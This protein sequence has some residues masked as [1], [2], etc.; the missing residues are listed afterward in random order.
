MEPEAAVEIWAQ[1]RAHTIMEGVVAE[2]EGIMDLTEGLQDKWSTEIAP[3]NSSSNN[4]PIM[5]ISNN[6]RDI[7]KSAH[8]LILHT[9]IHPVYYKLA[10]YIFGLNIS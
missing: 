1:V 3:S 10:I 6:N 8:S 5:L 4:N 2:E 9:E 7:T